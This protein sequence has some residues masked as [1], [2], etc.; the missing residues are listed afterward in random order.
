MKPHL[1]EIITMHDRVGGLVWHD[2][3]ALNRAGL[4]LTSAEKM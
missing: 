4:G 2:M 3:H 1:E